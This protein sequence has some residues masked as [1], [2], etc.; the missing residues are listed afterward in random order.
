MMTFEGA[1]TLAAVAQLQARRLLCQMG[2]TPWLWHADTL[3]RSFCWWQLLD[4]AA[5]AFSASTSCL[6][7]C[8]IETKVHVVVAQST[9]ACTVRW[10]ARC[11]RVLQSGCKQLERTCRRWVMAVAMPAM[12]VALSVFAV[13]ATDACARATSNA[14]PIAAR[15]SPTNWSSRLLMVVDSSLCRHCSHRPGDAPSTGCF[16][17]ARRC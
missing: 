15:W 13:L 16:V 1:G 4:S 2:C 5:C 17:T 9:M 14:D 10:S 12:H 11:S 8:N 6:L 7:V 3:S